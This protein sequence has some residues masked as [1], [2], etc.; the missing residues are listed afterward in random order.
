VTAP[1]TV[2]RTRFSRNRPWTPERDPSRKVGTLRPTSRA[3]GATSRAVPLGLLGAALAGA[4]LLSTLTKQLTQRPRPPATQAIGHWAGFAF[5]SGHATSATA[6]YLRDARRP[7]GRRHPRWGRKVVWWVAAVVAAG[8]VGLSRL[9]LGANW[10]TDVLGGHA[11][12]AAWL[13]G[14]LTLARTVLTLRTPATTPGPPS[15]AGRSRNSPAR[16]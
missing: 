3:A 7:A 1:A 8:L 10:L 6:A 9:Y 16:R 15:P 12:G 5:P 2:A 4:W 14:L 11:L 13:T